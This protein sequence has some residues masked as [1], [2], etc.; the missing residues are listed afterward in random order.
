ML[1]TII[2]RNAR[3]HSNAPAIIFEDR[4]LT[5]REFAT[6]A[7]RLANALARIGVRRG[8]RVAVLSQNCP[9]YM[10]AFAAGELGGFITVTINYRL[11]APEVGYILSDSR[12]KVLIAEAP[13]L[14]RVSAEARSKL[15]H[16]ITF[17]GNGPDLD[18]ETLLAAEE[19]VPPTTEVRP[20][21]IAYLIY[22]SGTTGRPKGVMLDSSRAD[23]VRTGHRDRDGRTANR[24]R[25]DHDAALSHRC[26]EHLAHALDAGLHD[27]PPPRVSHRAILRKSPRACR[28]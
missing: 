8:D 20:D 3:L 18:Y 15:E 2:L 11:A 9:E 22:T 7:F 1:G 6:R 10:E 4:T 13:L 19:P 28:D 14:E 5:H 25:G 27:R 24:S 23:V 21:D 16:V 12:P 17:G 26:Q